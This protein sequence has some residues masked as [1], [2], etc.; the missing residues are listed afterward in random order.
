MQ[1]LD[2]LL[3]GAVL[4]VA[5][6]YLY[7]KFVVRKGCSCGSSCHRFPGPGAGNSPCGGACNHGKES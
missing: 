5:L 6:W 3:T 7:R 4:A 1:L 2:L